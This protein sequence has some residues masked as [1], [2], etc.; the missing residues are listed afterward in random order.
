[1]LTRRIVNFPDAR[2]VIFADAAGDKFADARRVSCA[3]QGHGGDG[4]ARRFRCQGVEIHENF[5]RFLV[6]LRVASF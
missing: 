1:M 3:A 6:D 5:S 4:R 2:I